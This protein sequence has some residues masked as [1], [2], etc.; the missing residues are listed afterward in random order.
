MTSTV[1]GGGEESPKS[2]QNSHNFD[3]AFYSQVGRLMSD[4]K[5]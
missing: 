5:E 2:R 3:T 1:G 4:L